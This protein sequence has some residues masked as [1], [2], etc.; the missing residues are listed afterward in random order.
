MCLV[1]GSRASNTRYP[2]GKRLGN[3]VPRQ[4]AT[5]KRWLNRIPAGLI[6][7]ISRASRSRKEGIQRNHGHCCSGRV[8]WGR[9]GC[10]CQRAGLHPCIPRVHELGGS[11]A[12]PLPCYRLLICSDRFK[13]PS[14]CFCFQNAKDS[15]I[16]HFHFLADFDD[17]STGA[18]FGTTDHLPRSSSPAFPPSTPWLTPSPPEENLHLSPRPFDD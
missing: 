13:G 4:R 8:V 15:P 11:P 10:L 7:A 2:C 1:R 5:A 14:F 9:V 12:P 16:C 18:T 3:F 17:R 6:H